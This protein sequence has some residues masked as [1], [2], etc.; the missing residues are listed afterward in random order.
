MNASSRRRPWSGPT[1][2]LCFAS[3]LGALPS[4]TAAQASPGG[5]CAADT[6][7]KLAFLEEKLEAG[8]PHARYWW[9]GFTAFYGI[10]VVVTSTQ[11]ALEDD[12][13]HRAVDVVSAV[14]ALF[15][16]TRL[17]V[18][19]PSA[20]EGNAPM[21]AVSLAEPGG[22]ERRLQVGEELLRRNAKEANR[23]YSWKAHA[24]NVGVNV[25]GAVIAGEGWGERRDAW[26]SAAIGIVVGEVMNYLHPW[27]ARGDLEE[28]ERR[29]APVPTGESVSWHV[30]PHWGGARL[31]VRF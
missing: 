6:A 30:V 16:T 10:G 7:A 1:L 28:Y 27:Q 22:C 17:L 8:R 19:P 2:G 12:A 11:A 4:S 26:T 9:G 18:A 24:A 23:W 5:V 14:K 3:M 13:G 25:A 31:E 15:G 20:K 21:V 29:F